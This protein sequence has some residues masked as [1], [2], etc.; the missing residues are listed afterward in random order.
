MML[1]FMEE[2]QEMRTLKDKRKTPEPQ[3]IRKRE[4][5]REREN[6]KVINMEAGK[7]S[8]FDSAED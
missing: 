4:R 1:V 3:S 7:W 8:F 5:M 2:G 6:V